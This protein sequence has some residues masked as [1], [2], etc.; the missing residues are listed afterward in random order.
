MLAVRLSVVMP[1][2]N[3][4]ATIREIVAKVMSV[5]IAK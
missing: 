4:V 3:E 1:V 2:F 5:P